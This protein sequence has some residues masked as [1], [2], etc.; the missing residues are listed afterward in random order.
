MIDFSAPLAGI[1]KAEA[2]LQLAAERLATAADP[3]G[4]AVDLSEVAVSLL[5]ARTAVQANVNVIRTEAELSRALVDLL[6]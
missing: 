1:Q 3:R 6:A 2:S 5:T 4:D